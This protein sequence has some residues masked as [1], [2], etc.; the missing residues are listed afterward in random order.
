MDWFLYDSDLRHEKVKP[1]TAQN[2]PEYG[3]FVTVRWESWVK[4]KPY[5]GIYSAMN[6][7]SKQTSV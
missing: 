4:E 7:K 2:M 3:F 6:S 1:I 5:F